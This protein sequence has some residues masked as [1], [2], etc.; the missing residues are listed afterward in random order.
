MLLFKFAPQPLLLRVMVPETVTWSSLRQ[1]TV[2]VSLLTSG[3]MHEQV[4]K[5]IMERLGPQWGEMMKATVVLKVEEIYSVGLGPEA[6][7]RIA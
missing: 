7:K 3:D 5:M 2:S 4:K 1:V 6:G